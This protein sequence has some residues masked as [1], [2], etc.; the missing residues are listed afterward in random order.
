MLSSYTR[1]TYRTAMIRSK[2]MSLPRQLMGLCGT[3]SERLYTSMCCPEQLA[4]SG[5]VAPPQNVVIV[6][7]LPIAQT[8]V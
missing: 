1:L 3:S 7:D 5:I 6:T 2:L 8:G 4:C